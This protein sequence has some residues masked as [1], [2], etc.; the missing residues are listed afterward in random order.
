[1]LFLSLNAGCNNVDATASKS[2]E[3]SPLIIA[4]RG[5]SE[6]EPEHTLRSYSR[7]IKDG[8][9]F[10]E[11]DLRMTKDGKLVA[12]H[13]EDVS[14]TTDGKGN[15]EN[16]SLKHVKEL[17]TEKDQ[18]VL[19]LEEIFKKYGDSTKYYIETREGSKGRLVME[20]KLID[21]LNR[22]KLLENNQVIIQ[23][24]SAKSLKKVR[25]LNKE[26]PIV[27]LV[28]TWDAGKLSER[29]KDYKK[30]AY[31]IGISSQTLSD[32]EVN[33]IHDENMDVHTFFRVELEKEETKRMIELKVDG[34]FTNNPA[35][36][37]KLLDESK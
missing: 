35:Y 2:K 4:H 23:S 22:Y 11:I 32:K 26:V 34:M 36:L 30:Y 7:A 8:A 25:K 27:Q 6:L 9:D 13:D 3:Y 12:F 21:I 16:L 14:R 15:I 17:R 20:K 18:Q 29:I 10:I 28:Q 33:M 1:M 5:A 24:F 19:T 31:A 37:N